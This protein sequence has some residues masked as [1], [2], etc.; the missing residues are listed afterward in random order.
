MTADFS[1]VRCKLYSCISLICEVFISITSSVENYRYETKSKDHWNWPYVTCCFE[2]RIQPF[3]ILNHQ[4]FTQTYLESIFAARLSNYI[5]TQSSKL[6]KLVTTGDIYGGVMRFMYNRRLNWLMSNCLRLV[7]IF[8]GLVL[9]EFVVIL[10]SDWDLILQYWGSWIT[11]LPYEPC[12]CMGGTLL[13]LK[14]C[15]SW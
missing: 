5:F 9:F 14:S 4:P 15:N 1:Y 8:L 11:T 2:N 10:Q 7:D 12:E 6:F 3:K 13:P